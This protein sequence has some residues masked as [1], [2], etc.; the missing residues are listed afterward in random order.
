MADHRYRKIESYLL[1]AGA[2]GD[3]PLVRR[4]RHVIKS[5]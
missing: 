2:H 5:D 4:N 1:A 3:Q